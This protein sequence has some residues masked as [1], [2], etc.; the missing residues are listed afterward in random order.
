METLHAKSPCCRGRIYRFGKRR[1]QC[2]K[3]SRTWRIRRKRRGPKRKRISATIMPGVIRKDVTVTSIARR[4][5]CSPT[6]IQKRVK[7]AMEQLLRS[8]N[9]PGIPEGPLI[10]IID[11]MWLRFRGSGWHIMYLMALRAING[12]VA[13]FVDP[14]SLPGKETSVGWQEAIATLPQ[15]IRKRI[16][17]LVSDGLRG[18][19][20]L[21]QAN[22]WIFQRCHFHLFAKFQQKHVLRVYRIA[23]RQVRDDILTALEETVR[24][25]SESRLLELQNTLRD[26]SDNPACPWYLRM[27]V[28]E[29]L[30]YLG[31][32]RS[33]LRY[34]ELHLPIT[35]NTAE[36]MIR[37]LRRL[38]RKSQ[39]FRTPTSAYRWITTFIRLK[40]TI[41]CN[42]K[43][44]NQN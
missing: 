28:R 13:Y 10:L 6:A 35:T 36:T 2:S 19:K 26:L 37:L 25:T 14:V 34:P 11:G 1:R 8:P 41:A 16:R 31:D 30:R 9:R 20:P 38:V 12:T 40:R 7:H 27:Q 33:Y 17:A 24:T 42:G 18:V 23:S 32:F 44:I 21:A 15:S 4:R 3:C 39:G 22:G 5:H 29:F 43:I